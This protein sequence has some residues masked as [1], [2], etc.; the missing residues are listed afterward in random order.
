MTSMDGTRTEPQVAGRASTVTTR[1]HQQRATPA[2]RHLLL[3]RV[4]AGVPLL[5]IG[6][7]HVLSPD[8]PMRPLVDAAGIPF[9]AVV[10][11]VAV[12]FEILAGLSLLLGLWARIGGALAEPTI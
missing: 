6:L 1:L 9:A 8:A 10:S 2:Y 7:A 11:P 5:V 3:P 4:V 12:G